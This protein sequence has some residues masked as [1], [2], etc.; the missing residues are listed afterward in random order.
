MDNVVR[1]PQGPNDFA[2]YVDADGVLVDYDAAIRALGFDIDPAYKLKLNRSETDDPFKRTMY[3]AIK[4][5]EFFFEAPILKGAIRLWKHIEWSRPIV[6]TAAPKFGASEDDYHLDPHWLG[7]AYHKRR[8][9]EE[10]FLPEVR[11]PVQVRLPT[12]T[13]NAILARVPLE[14]DRFICATS[15]SKWRFMQRKRALHQ[16]LIDDRPANCI[17]WA[18]AGGF[19]IVHRGNAQ[20]VMDR[21]DWYR[22]SHHD[23]KD[24]MPDPAVGG[25]AVAGLP[26]H[27]LMIYPTAG[28]VDQ[29]SAE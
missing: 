9:F 28:S 24:M 26:E 18:K 1:M 21:I 4:G 23:I 3:E 22:Q 2:F 15:A 12:G 16:I 5:T 7:A 13:H 19:A 17:A 20:D 8:F 29:W 10:K 6:L 11:G 14:D 27:D 25:G